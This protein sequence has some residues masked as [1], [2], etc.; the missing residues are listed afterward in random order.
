MKRFGILLKLNINF[1]YLGIHFGLFLCR[2]PICFQ[3]F[4]HLVGE[5]YEGYNP[6]SSSQ[7]VI[8]L[9]VAL[10]LFVLGLITFSKLCWS[11]E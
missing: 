8:T 7:P 9:V 11:K 10:L 4:E 1:F 3:I 5:E 2:L 6:L